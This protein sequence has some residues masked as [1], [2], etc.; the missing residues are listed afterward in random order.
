L[1]GTTS[2]G[3]NTGCQNGAGCGIAYAIDL[4]TGSETILHVFTGG[5]DGGTP[6][7]GLTWFSGLLYG[8]TEV[9]GSAGYGAVFSMDP[10]TG[11]ETVLYNADGGNGNGPS[12]D[13]NVHGHQLFGTTFSGGQHNAGLVFEVDP[14]NA[15]FRDVHDFGGS[16]DAAFPLG[17]LIFGPG[18]A[19]GT[20]V[21]GGSD[22]DGTVFAVDTAS[23]RERVLHSFGGSAASPPDGRLPI[24]GLV[25]LDGQLYG[26]T[27]FGGAGVSTTD[28]DCAQGCGTVFRVDAKTGAEAVIYSFT[29]GADGGWPSTG[30]T[31]ANGRL[32]GTGLIGGSTGFGVV[33]EI[34]PHRGTERV[35]HNFSIYTNFGPPGA[36]STS[37]GEPAGAMLYH[38]GYLYGTTLVGGQSS[39]GDGY[40]TVF[41]L[42]P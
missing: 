30:L 10:V 14:A 31:V 12:A 42:H 41:R 38:G 39:S 25:M 23:G 27:R 13:L 36:P 24:G 5:T 28:P 18:V 3:G 33:F 32:Y 1:F 21:E 29:G 15:A 19:Y 35:L 17:G 34:N 22:K 7:A 6:T 4:R 11:S 26:T 9:G 16:P 40:G 2:A 37:A 20:S 8:A